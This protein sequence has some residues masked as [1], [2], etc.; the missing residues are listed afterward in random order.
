MA[1]H[2][3]SGERDDADGATSSEPGAD[4]TLAALLGD[5]REL[6]DYL[7]ER[8]RHTHELAQRFLENARRDPSARSYDERKAT[9][10]EYQHYILTD[11]QSDFYLWWEYP[12]A[13]A[14]L[15]T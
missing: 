12:K 4:A 7:R 5:L 15:A 2:D 9:M 8:G 3:E 6:R 13:P 14:R 10:L 1:E 11:M